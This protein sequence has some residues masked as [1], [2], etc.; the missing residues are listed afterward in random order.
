MLLSRH[1]L[2]FITDKETPQPKSGMSAYKIKIA[3]EVPFVYIE[4]TSF[5]IF[6]YFIVT[7]LLFNNP[8]SNLTQRYCISHLS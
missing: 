2:Y 5:A 1:L 7:A 4:Q 6:S 3:K 8:F